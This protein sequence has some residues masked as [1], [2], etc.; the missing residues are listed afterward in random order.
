ML[1]GLARIAESYHNSDSL[2]L[3]RN[4]NAT[5]TVGR[6][7][8]ELLGHA[9]GAIDGRRKSVV[10]EGASAVLPAVLLGAVQAVASTHALVQRAADKVPLVH[11][12]LG[13]DGRKSGQDEE[14]RRGDGRDGKRPAHDC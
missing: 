14:R 13:G 7:V 1:E 6:A 2:A 5:T 10:G 8:P 12:H 4:A 11:G 9:G 3:V